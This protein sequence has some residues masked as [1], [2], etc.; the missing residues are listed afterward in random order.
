MFGLAAMSGAALLNH[1]PIVGAVLAVACLSLLGC[2]L[3]QAG[4]SLAAV[5]R[6]S[7][8]EQTATLEVTRSSVRDSL[9][10]KAL[11]PP[12]NSAAMRRSEPDV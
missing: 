11:F 1:R 4:R 10:G 9:S 5:I 12:M 6:V 2:A 3:A 7:Q 8:E